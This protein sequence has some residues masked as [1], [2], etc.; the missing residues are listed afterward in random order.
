M[1]GYK[2]T[3]DDFDANILKTMGENHNISFSAYALTK[4]IF[5]TI[6]NCSQIKNKSEVIKQRLMKLEKYGFINSK[7]DDCSTLYQ[8]RKHKIFFMPRV[9]IEI[10]KKRVGFDNMLMIKNHSSRW[11]I[12]QLDFGSSDYLKKVFKGLFLE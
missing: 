6:N 9:I 8:F 1:N 5:P 12:T 7:K 3:I 4:L 11:G 10:H 2:I